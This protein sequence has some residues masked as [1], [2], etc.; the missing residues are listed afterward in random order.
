M[1]P[2]AKHSSFLG[3]HE[4]GTSPLCHAGIRLRS[5][6][7]TRQ[8]P[9][10]RRRSPRPRS[11]LPQRR[12]RPS[13]PGSSLNPWRTPCPLRASAQHQPGRRSGEKQKGEVVAPK[14]RAPK[15]PPLC[16]PDPPN[17]GSLPT[18]HARWSHQ[19]QASV[20]CPRGRWWPHLGGVD[21]VEGVVE[22]KVDEA[23]QG[24]VKL[25]ESGHHTVI[26]ICGVLQAQGKD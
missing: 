14:P 19:A 10:T 12:Q 13:P 18:T 6:V 20:A 17:M 1:A 8:A 16:H 15:H 26:N 22:A 9:H 4:F 23:Q 7:P 3:Q 2:E 24:G 11:I 21:Q 5:S 25:G